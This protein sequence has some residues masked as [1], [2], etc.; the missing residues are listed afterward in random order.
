MLSSANLEGAR[1]CGVEAVQAD[2][3]RAIL[4]H[5]DLSGARLAGSNFSEANLERAI[6]ENCDLARANLRDAVLVG[7]RRKDTALL[8]ADMRGA[9][10]DARAGKAVEDL[11][12]TIEETLNA[13][14]LWVETNGREGQP[15]DLSDVDLRSITV[16]QRANLNA[17]LAPRAIL[18]GLDLS[19]AQ[20][21]GAQLDGAD[22]RFACL[23]NAN[24]RGINLKGAKLANA[25]L[26]DADLG[27]LWLPGDQLLRAS[28]EHA[29]ARYADFRGTELR[30]AIFD[31]ADLAYADLTGAN[32]RAT[33]FHGTML[34][35]TKLS[36]Q[37]TIEANVDDMRCDS[38]AVAV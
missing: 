16:L 7:V 30:L 3:S 34:E 32:L 20:L 18:Y 19:G 11:S 2:F 27:P 23:K 12:E 4:R 17:V 14:R 36:F 25:D 10:T 9:L 5:C 15:A 8:D 31:E 22:L 13:H 28:L 38:A 35:G 6:L 26:R 29:D 21:Q 24:M 1:M 37:A 33:N